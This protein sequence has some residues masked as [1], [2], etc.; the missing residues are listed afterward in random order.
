MASKLI[1]YRNRPSVR[2]S[3]PILNQSSSHA[4]GLVLWIP[5]TIFHKKELITGRDLTINTSLAMTNV[6]NHGPV[7]STQI[8]NTEMAIVEDSEDGEFDFGLSH[9]F[10]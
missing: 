8:D 6:A 2:S 7:W 1:P 10:T 9:P 3:I 4:D 5:A